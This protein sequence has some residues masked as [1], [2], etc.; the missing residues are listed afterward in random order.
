MPHEAVFD[1]RGHMYIAER[2][3][4]VVRRSMARQAHLDA[5]GN[6]RRRVFGRLG[7]CCPGTAA[8]AAQH[9]HCAGDQLLICDI[10]NHRIR[11]VDLRT[12]I[13]NTIGGTGE[14]WPTPDGAP[15]KG[16]PLNGPRTMVIDRDGTIYLAL[17]EGQRALPHRSE[18]PDAA[19]PRRHRRAGLTGDGG[20]ARAAKLSGPKGLAL[21]GRNLYVADT[22]SHTIRRVNLDRASSRRCSARAYAETVRRRIPCN[23]SCPGRTAC[24]RRPTGRS[25]SRTVK[26]IA[27]V[28]SGRK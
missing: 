2:D 9:L 18:D 4:H 16:T 6:G 15:L 20:P 11:A 12:G 13:I 25:T 22:E 24:L 14:R 28:C 3:S 10:G 27:F 23:A 1:A 5:R 21:S 8:A 19:S 26:P 17:R 7:S